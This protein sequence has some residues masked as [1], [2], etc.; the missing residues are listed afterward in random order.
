MIPP[1]LDG[2]LILLLSV[3]ISITNFKTFIRLL[4]RAMNVLKKYKIGPDLAMEQ[5]FII[6]KDILREL[7][8]L[9]G[10]TS[11]DTV[12]DLGAGTGAIAD[13]LAKKAKKVYAIE[14]DGRF[15]DLLLDRFRKYDNVDV[16][17]D[18]V[19]T[20]DFPQFDK[21]VCNLPYNVYEQVLRRLFDRGFK[22]AVIIC[23]YGFAKILLAKPGDKEYSS[24]TELVQKH[25]SI[26]KLKDIPKES[27]FP[28][29]RVT[30]SIVRLVPKTR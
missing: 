3:G 8:K 16:V 21:I 26:E 15:Y 24:F 4:L 22:L 10:I 19:R 12:L 18:D 27:F 20:M 17:I 28:E 29:P 2:S 13:S 6:D 1:P 5:F 25:F 30:S 7:P 11:E 9:A 14:R 23:S